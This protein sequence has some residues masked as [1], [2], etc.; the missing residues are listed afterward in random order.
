MHL[1]QEIEVCW[2]EVDKYDSWQSRTKGM[3]FYSN[4]TCNTT[5]I[6]QN[7]PYQPGG[8]GVVLSHTMEPRVIGKVDDTWGLG[9]WVWTRLQGKEHTVIILSAY[10]PCK[11]SSSGVQTVYE[12]HTI[13][14]PILSDPRTQFLINLK[15]TGKNM[16]TWLS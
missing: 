10:W 13:S 15:R 2:P 16:T 14:L 5:E 4:L 6:D 12:Q 3:G 7:I 11:P 8:T 1:W 9:R